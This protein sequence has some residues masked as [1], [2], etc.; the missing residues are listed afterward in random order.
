MRTMKPSYM[1]PRRRPALFSPV[2]KP[3]R[4][5]KACCLP[6]QD[7]LRAVLGLVLLISLAAGLSRLLAADQ[8]QPDIVWMKGGLAGRVLALAASPDGSVVAAANADTS[9][10]WRNDSLSA[11]THASSNTSG[12]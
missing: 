4:F 2:Q 10:K 11:C 5:R 8:D 3:N 12:E 1:C 7:S 6:G 9:I